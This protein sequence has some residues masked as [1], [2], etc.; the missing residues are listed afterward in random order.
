MKLRRLTIT[1][2]P[3]L[4]PVLYTHS[5]QTRLCQCSWTHLQLRLYSAIFLSRTAVRFSPEATGPAR[6]R[7]LITPLLRNGE[8]FFP[9]APFFKV[10]LFWRHLPIPNTK[11]KRQR[12]IMAGQFAGS[13]AGEKTTDGDAQSVVFGCSYHRRYQEMTVIWQ[14]LTCQPYKRCGARPTP[15]SRWWTNY[16]PVC[17]L[18][19]TRT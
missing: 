4:R 2:E 14:T 3:L 1:T 16:W 12:D 15:K 19:L 6:P 18:K 13:A 10:K 8:R 11:K 7:S 9:P 5:K 17:V